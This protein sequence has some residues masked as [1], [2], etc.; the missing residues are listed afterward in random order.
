MAYYR[1]R[2]YPHLAHDL[3]A[4]TH[5]LAQ[6]VVPT[7]RCSLLGRSL[8]ALRKIG[9]TL[10]VDRIDPTLGYIEGNMQLLARDLNSAKGAGM[11]VP[12]SIVHRLLWKLERV[13][14]D[15]HSNVPGATHRD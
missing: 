7:S 13:V 1:E 2:Q 12:Q 14:N 15:K 11:V 10:T 5:M 9:Q 8:L 4:H 3:N 6:A